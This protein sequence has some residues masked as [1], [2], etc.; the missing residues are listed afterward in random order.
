[1]NYRFN[2]EQWRQLTKLGLYEKQILKLER[3]VLPAASA[4]LAEEA[5]IQDVRDKLAEVMKAVNAA[6]DVTA[7]LLK[8]S[9]PAWLEAFQRIERADFVVTVEDQGDESRCDGEAPVLTEEG[10]LCP[11]SLEN[12]K[13]ELR[14][15]RESAEQRPRESVERAY[16]MLLPLSRIAQRASKAF[17][18]EAAET[19]PRRQGGYF[20]I[21]LIDEALRKGFLEHQEAEAAEGNV[22]LPPYNLRPSNSQ[23][24]GFW[25]VVVICYEAIGHSGKN[26]ERPIRSYNEWLQNRPL[27][28]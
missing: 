19:K 4:A 24:S 20:E 7:S 23:T 21:Q 26:P 15:D 27:T 17:E 11:P 13:G 6:R 10:W 16:R 9:T 25:R 22:Q 8:T 1:M 3:K 2:E 18:V 28:Q 12:D 14:D 5:T